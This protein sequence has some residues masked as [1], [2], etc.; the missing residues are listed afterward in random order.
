MRE[1]EL[2]TQDWPIT[3]EFGQ[4]GLDGLNPSFGSRG[5]RVEQIPHQV[6]VD[7][8]VRAQEDVIHIHPKDVLTIGQ[9]SRELAGTTTGFNALRG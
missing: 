5:A 7:R 8:A 6:G 2:R 3:H 4:S 9:S 1:R